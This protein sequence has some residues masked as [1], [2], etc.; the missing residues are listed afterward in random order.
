M[1]SR[2]IELRS[3][4]AIKDYLSSSTILDPRISDGDTEPVWDGQIYINREKGHY[5]RIPA[6]IKGKQV[7]SIPAKA[8]R[9]IEVYN[10]N[11]YLRDGG[12]IFFV[13]YLLGETHHIYYAPLAPIDL[14]RYIK[15]AQGN[16]TISVKLSPLSLD[17]KTVEREFVDFHN[18]CLKQKSF[19]NCPT[20]SLTDA[21]KD[22]KSFK[23]CF[24]SCSN[25]EE[26]FNSLKS[27]SVYLYT[28]IKDGCVET[29]YPIGDQAYTLKFSPYI[30]KEI[31]VNGKT[32][33]SEYLI[34]NNENGFSISLDN[35]LVLSCET[36]DSN[37]KFNITYTYS[38]SHLRRRLHCLYFM[39]D[40]MNY[41]HI[42]IG[43]KSIHLGSFN[44]DNEKAISNEI[45]YLERVKSLF[46]YFH[47]EVDIDIKK[48]TK[49]DYSNINYISRAVLDDEL[50]YHKTPVDAVST[51]E[52]GKYKFLLYCQEKRKNYYRIIDYFRCTEEL[53]IAYDDDNNKLK[54]LVTSIYSLALCRADLATISNIDFNNLVPSYVSI[55]PRN[56]K[57]HERANTDL[58]SALNV[59]DRMEQKND[60]LYYA[61]LELCDWI[62]S[63]DSN[64]IYLINKFQI[65]KRKRELTKEESNLLI[66]KMPIDNKLGTQTAI[67][68]LL[69]N[70]AMA[71]YTFG[72]MKESEKEFFKSLPIYFFMN[73]NKTD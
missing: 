3:V 27:R 52:I 30:H 62:V 20:L 31:K 45:K 38:E 73:D 11:N 48:F 23:F 10:L 15:N 70:K 42:E 35:C 1:N 40:V 7:V 67:H 44:G 55:I 28:T 60:K 50:L 59:Y 24:T 5:D 26:A 54:N 37:T 57:V 68:L 33:F 58:L 65:I 12:V 64:I 8:T 49:L 21:F 29:D 13:V 51:I 22:G 43:D 47:I 25:K 61:L 9:S 4:T 71:E 72:T 19:Q 39:R 69:N 66:S 56:N 34:E 14:K 41:L 6:Q 53:K 2:Q 63:R 18:D 46:E 36:K 16:K 32:Y 17:I